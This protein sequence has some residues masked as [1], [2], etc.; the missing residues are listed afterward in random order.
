MK[1]FNRSERYTLFALYGRIIMI[2]I[3]IIIKI[4]R[5]KIMI[6]TITITIVIIIIAKRLQLIKQ[7]HRWRNSEDLINVK[8]MHLLLQTHI[9][10]QNIGY[11]HLYSTQH[12][13]LF[14]YRFRNHHNSPRLC[15]IVCSKS[16]EMRTFL[17]VYRKRFQYVVQCAKERLLL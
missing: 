8:I 13:T 9:F 16:N 5:I 2:I 12:T 7:L 4:I 14:G 15:H 1:I 10:I 17:I 3:I 6:I 11:I